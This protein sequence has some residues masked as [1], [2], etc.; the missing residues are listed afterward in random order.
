MVST[1]INTIKLLFIFYEIDCD[2]CN[3]FSEYNNIHDYSAFKMLITIAIFSIKN[4][5]QEI[6]STIA[7]NPVLTHPRRSS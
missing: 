5:N 6:M 1:C 7:P 2:K 3:I 4:R